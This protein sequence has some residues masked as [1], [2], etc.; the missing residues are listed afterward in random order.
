MIEI[1]G[2]QV[3]EVIQSK[4]KKRILAEIAVK[5]AK[6]GDILLWGKVL[7]PHKFR[8]PF[9]LPLHQYLVD[10]RKAK[11]TSTEA[12]RGHAKTTIQCFLIPMFQSVIEPGQ[13]SHYLNVQAT[14]AK[15]L[16]VNISMRHEFEVNE[17]FKYIYGDYVGTQKWTDGQFALKNGV[18]FTAVGAGQSIRGINYL[19]KRPDYTNV[20]DLYDHEDINNPQSTKK[21]NEW[22]WSD[23]HPAQ[24]DDGPTSMHVQG[25]AINKFDLLDETKK[26]PGIVA[27][28]FKTVTNWETKEVLWPEQ[29]SFDERMKE[30]EELRIPSVIWMRENQNERRDDEV[31]IIKQHWLDGWEYDPAD[32]VF[33][34]DFELVSVRAGCDP[35]IGKNMEADFTGVA[36]VMKARYADGKGD[37]Y[38]IDDLANEHLSQHKRIQKLQEMQDKRAPLGKPLIQRYDIEAISGF[39]DFAS[40]AIRTTNLPIRRIPSVKDKIT[41]LEN[42]SHYFENKKV[43]IN[44]RLDKKLIDALYYQLTTNYPDHDDIRDAV[45]LCLDD[46]KRGPTVT[47]I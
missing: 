46:S 34:K 9:C 16:S 19:N 39:D 3:T 37:F 26:S 38:F 5:A 41:N 43:R 10:T 13:Y 4:I 24:A 45:L 28:T 47:V 32:I 7:F 25:T 12:P 36:V 18:A 23:L 6:A 27:R 42:K 31:S 15:A 14:G 2:V 35:S 21:K 33:D 1:N 29:A 17:M 44:K 20:D 30:R 22:F 8:L 11:F 40:E